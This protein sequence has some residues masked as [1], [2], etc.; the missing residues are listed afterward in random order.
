[1]TAGA[2]R[3]VVKQ[4]SDTLE[5]ASIEVLA[6]VDASAVRGADE[7]S[8]QHGGQTQWLSVTTAARAA[9]SQ[10]AEHRDRDAAKALLGDSP[11]A[12]IVSDRCADLKTQ[13]D[14]IHGL[15]AQGAR[16]RPQ[17][18]PLLQRPAGPRDRAV[19]VHPPSRH[20]GHNNAAERAL[21]QAVQWRKTSY[22]TQTDHGDRL[23]ECLLTLRETCRIQG[24][25]REPH[26]KLAA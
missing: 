11:T 25:R 15:L 3:G 5:D 16:G 17:D 12:T 21:R 18:Q 9:R 4:T 22:G 19:D 10:I 2:Q 26:L 14:A 23:V 24:R 1:V 8:W 7:T 6:T 20:P 13:R